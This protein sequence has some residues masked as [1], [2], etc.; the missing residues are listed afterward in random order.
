MQVPACLYPIVLIGAIVLLVIAYE[1]LMRIAEAIVGILTGPIL[2][3]AT[4]FVLAFGFLLSMA[5]GQSLVTGEW[6]WVQEI[7]KASQTPVR[8]Y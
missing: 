1:L 2:F 6:G 5:I 8:V 3:I 4:I 7:V